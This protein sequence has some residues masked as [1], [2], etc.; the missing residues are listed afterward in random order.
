GSAWAYVSPVSWQVARDHILLGDP[1]QLQLDEAQATTLTAA[2]KPFFAEDGI[3]LHPDTPDRWLAEGD[4]FRN[5]ATA[6]LDRRAGQD[7]DAWIP[8]APEAAPLRR[9]QNEMQ[10]LLYTHALNDERQAR[11]LPPVNSVWVSGSGAL[12]A[13]WQPHGQPEPVV[14]RRLAE[15]ALRQD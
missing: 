5:L 10:M 3:Q 13:G 7:I 14:P 12:P 15:A 9:L 2:M 11:G 1:A 6:S 4:I 8:R